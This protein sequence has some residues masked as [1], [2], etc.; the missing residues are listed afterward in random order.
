MSP[1]A[2]SRAYL[3]VDPA[4]TSESRQAPLANAGRSRDQ[5]GG[6]RCGGG[7]GN[8]TDRDYAKGAVARITVTLPLMCHGVD[9]D[10]PLPAFQVVLG[11]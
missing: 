11:R 1:S 9:A 4:D 6:R 3:A 2:T 8:S 7:Q 5:H 10:G